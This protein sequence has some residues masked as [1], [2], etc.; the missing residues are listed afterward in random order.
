M[1]KSLMPPTVPR[2]SITLNA[3]LK[4]SFSLNETES[5]TTKSE[6]ELFFLENSLD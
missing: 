3:D 6:S 2:K 4:Y 5:D 1:S